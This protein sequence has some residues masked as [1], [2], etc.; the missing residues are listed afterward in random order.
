MFLSQG[1]AREPPPRL[2][3]QTEVQLETAVELLWTWVLTRVPRAK[4][5]AL[6]KVWAGGWE[7][8]SRSDLP[9]AGISF[10]TLS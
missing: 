2:A 10:L 7:S 5:R 1:A 6:G 8:V 9:S 4:L 3:K